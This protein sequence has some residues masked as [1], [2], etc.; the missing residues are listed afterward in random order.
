[1]ILTR[2][3]PPRYLRR[4]VLYRPHRDERDEQAG[5]FRLVIEFFVRYIWPH[6]VRFGTYLILSAL[7]GVAVY[8]RTFYGLVVVDEIL[9]ITPPPASTTTVEHPFS[10]EEG[11]TS[12]QRR[13]EEGAASEA[14]HERHPSV[15]PPN[16]GR[17][18]FGFFFVYLATVV[19]L[20][21]ASRYAVRSRHHVAKSITVRL[22]EDLHTKIISL[23]SGF[24]QGTTPGRL[25]A[26]ILSDVEMVQSQLLNVTATLFTQS[27]IFVVGFIILTAI[28]W[29]CT[30][31]VLLAA[32]PFSIA[33]RQN[34]VAMRTTGREMRHSNSCLWG[35]VSQKLDAIR[36]IYAYGREKMEIM[37][38]FRLSAVFQRDA[39]EQQR[40]AASVGRAA[41]LIS[42]F[43]TQGIFIYCTV[44]VLSHRMTL[45]QMM[46]IYGTAATLFGPVVSITQL[47]QPIT[48]LLV[49]LQRATQMLRNPNVIADT[50]GARPFPA[51]LAL[52][53]QVHDVSF[54]YDA[55]SPYVLHN[56]NLNIPPGQ[57]LC[58]MGPS[59][60]GKT[61]LVNLLTRLYEPT[62]GRISID[63][64]SL[65]DI[66]LTSLRHHMTLVPQE[67]QI[68]SG[69]IRNNITYGYPR[70]TPREIMDAAKA[71]DCHDFIMQQPVK[72]ETIVGDKG[73]T[74]S[75]GQRQRISIARALI[76]HPDILVLDDCTSA[77][78]ANTERKIQ[79]TLTKQMV[80]K[81][82]IIVS[83]RVSMA[84]RCDT[85][86]VL[87]DGHI[88]ERGTHTH[89]LLRGGFYA[90]LY[91]QQTAG[92]HTEKEEKA[93]VR[94]DAS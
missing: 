10:R 54:R 14:H 50:P 59:G 33:I 56:L 92:S 93:E 22:R 41:S 3:F 26:R 52:G 2:K 44:C 68:I 84:M 81:T 57:W 72:Y 24:H 19:I 32:I 27:I 36:A 11:L 58:I 62:D 7:V 4:D 43:T 39:L 73:V 31:A 63:E 23:S 79:E 29:R 5:A 89:L 37:N 30:V 91:A 80:G 87:E 6:K 61:T 85:I 46:F 12:V 21:V 94:A 45:G 53:I 74:L 60:A 88:T 16:A 86:I 13:M 20:N 48:N 42:T 25:M 90:R 75:G 34:Q 17:K 38:F 9:V 76:T 70:A 67:A 77:L 69:T 49:V 71:A 78:D 15:R 64:I 28:D 83:Q 82:A 55:R 47:A 65:S 51:P 18:L 35:L 40:R 1:M 66:R 8:L